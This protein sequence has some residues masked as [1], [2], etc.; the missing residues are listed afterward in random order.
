MSALQ[1]VYFHEVGQYLRKRSL[2]DERHLPYTS[3]AV[4]P[5]DAL[6][7]GQSGPGA[8]APVAAVRP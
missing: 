8:G 1:A 5:L 6:P 3:A 7:P 2:V 4:S